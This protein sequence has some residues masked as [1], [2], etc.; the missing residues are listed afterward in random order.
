MQLFRRGDVGPA[1]AEI[2]ATLALLGLLPPEDSA[3]DTLR[4]SVFDDAC[5]HAVRT[6][7][8]QRG[9]S[10]D[11]I[12]GV[13]TYRALAAA[14]HRLGDR[15]LFYRVTHPFVGD[16]VTAL[17]ER[18][19]DLGFDAGRPDGI[20]GARTEHALRDFQRNYGLVVD[21][22]CGPRTLRALAQLKRSVVGGRP[23]LL[24]ESEEVRRAGPT[25]V[26][27][28]V[29]VDPGHGGAD[30]GGQAHGLVESAIV[31]DIASRLEAR[32]LAAGVSAY[33]SRGPDTGPS[34]ADRADF[35][36]STGADLMVSLH[37]DAAPSPRC[38][39]VATYHFGTG[40]DAGSTI[41][42]R[43]ASLV[44]REVVARTG[45][46][47]CHTHPKTWEVL[48]RTRMPAVR[49]ELGYLTNRSDAE[50]L[51]AAEFRDA[52]A[53]AILVAIQRLY[54]PPDLDPPTGQLRLPALPST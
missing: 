46:L 35:A 13:E 7:Q 1:V 49:L 21:G 11:G 45:L 5:D 37:V 52:V 3:P 15:L 40:R 25:L 30:P 42:E 32:L 26:G 47:D 41:G 43:L 31:G 4:D 6:F 44:Q 12:V 9:L 29:V 16:D 23:Q 38:N 33:L 20:F 2:R 34:D 22:T 39:G 51:A 24:R 54:L 10:V 27:K 17:Q 28:A 50:L 36:N 14:R 48:R 18:L 53:E 19:L 8:Q